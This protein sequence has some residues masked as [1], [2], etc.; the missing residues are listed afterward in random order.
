MN[1]VFHIE[2]SFRKFHLFLIIFRSVQPNAAKEH[3]IVRY[4]AIALYRKAIDAICILRQISLGHA[5]KLLDVVWVTGS[6][7]P[8]ASVLVR[9]EEKFK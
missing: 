4:F 3:N 1:F 9:M 7:G 8:G 6:R 5:M 2:F